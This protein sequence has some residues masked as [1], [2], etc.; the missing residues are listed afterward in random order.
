M[1]RG[2]R[3]RLVDPKTNIKEDLPFEIFFGGDSYRK[4][5]KDSS[6]IRLS[7]SLVL[8][9][10]IFGCVLSGNQSGAHMNATAV[11]LVHSDRLCRPRRRTQTLLR[12]RDHR[13]NHR[14]R[15]NLERQRL[16]AIG[17]VPYVFSNPRSTKSSF[18]FE[19]AGSRP[20]EN[21]MKST[22]RQSYQRRSLDNDKALKD[23]CYDHMVDYIAKGQVKRRPLW[24]TRRR[25][26][27]YRIKR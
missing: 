22:R 5:M 4:V 3:K 15:P 24:K 25:C 13:N 19:E 12:S 1:A 8:I 16:S 2:R 21:K 17:S 14:P 10:S 6:P 18:H 20:A 7:E 23:V 27:I 9:P 11:N 26:S